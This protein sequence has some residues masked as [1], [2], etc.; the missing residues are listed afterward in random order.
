MPKKK[1]GSDTSPSPPAPVVPLV[2]IGAS[3]GGIE[4]VTVL[5]EHLSPTTGLAFVYVQHLD[6]NADSQLTAI[7]GRA[8]AMPVREAG[9]L[10]RIQ[11]NEV[12][13]IPPTQDIEVVDGV[14]SLMPRQLVV[15]QHMPIDRFFISLAERQKEVAVAVLLSG[16]ASDG[17]RGLRAIKLAGGITFAQDETARFQ[18]MPRS[19][20]AENVVDRVLPPAEIARELEMLSRKPEFFIQAELAENRDNDTDEDIQAIILLLRK[21]VGVDFSN[22][23]IATI[24]R[25]IIRRMLLFKLDTLKDLHPAPQAPSTGDGAVV[26]RLAHQRNHVFPRL[27]NDGLPERGHL[28][29]HHQ[30]KSTPRANPNLDT[31]L[32]NGSGSLLAGH[33]AA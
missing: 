11:P 15:S 6:P 21:G 20:I 14:L 2:A 27:R 33:A 32:L 13:V 17:T 12:Y 8:T 26:Q 10:M 16:M 25:R 9:H 1:S 23:K 3:A 28:S 4:A 29:P 22:Y 31:G 5:L 24:R 18:S 30:P 7:L 19:A